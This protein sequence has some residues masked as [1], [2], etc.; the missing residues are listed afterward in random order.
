MLKCHSISHYP[1]TSLERRIVSLIYYLFKFSIRT[2]SIQH[3][4]ALL[5]AFF[6]E[7]FRRGLSIIGC[8]SHSGGGKRLQ[9]LLPRWKKAK[10][11]CYGQSSTQQDC[12]M[13]WEIL[14]KK[15]NLERSYVKLYPAQNLLLLCESRNALSQCSKIP[16]NCRIRNEVINCILDVLNS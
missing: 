5:L 13:Q 12:R 10:L 9:G 4:N 3:H 15:N 16:V 7:F 1:L 14:P 2:T 6:Q 8:K 11:C